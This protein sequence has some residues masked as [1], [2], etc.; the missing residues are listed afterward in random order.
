MRIKNWPAFGIPLLFLGFVGLGSVFVVT[1]VEQALILQFG[2]LLDTVRTPGLHV[3]LPFIQDVVYYDKRILDFDV[4]A[5][6]VTL[7]DQKRIM[8][9]TFTRYRIVDPARFYKTVR[10]EFGAQSRLA[11]LITGTLRS[12]L[13]ATSLQTLLSSERAGTLRVILDQVNKGVQGLGIQVV[14]VRIR[15]ADLPAE[16]SQAI[17]NRMISERQKEASEKRAEGQEKAQIIRANADLECTTL[18][19]DAERTAQEKMGAADQEALQTIRE[20]YGRNPAFAAFYQ[21]KEAYEEGLQ[22]GTVYILTPDHDFFKYF[23][24]K[25]R[26][27]QR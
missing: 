14:D 27:T 5:T 11:A 26:M 17:F 22:K 21:S 13:G 9:G 23:H 2:E 19:A 3:K 1:E 4:P 16:N 24:Q 10:N 6:E 12:I 15:Q 18:M 20:A 8:V 7:G 25:E